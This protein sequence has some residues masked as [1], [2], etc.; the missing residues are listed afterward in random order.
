VLRSNSQMS[1][2]TKAITSNQRLA[3]VGAQVTTRPHRR[4]KGQG[5]LTRSEILAAARELLEAE[6]RKGTTIR[7]IA[8]KA[9]ISSTALYFY[10]ADLDAIL[11]EISDS[12]ST[13]LADSLTGDAKRH[14]DPLTAVESMLRSYVAFGLANPQAYALTFVDPKK[15]GQTV[16]IERSPSQAE[17]AVAQFV[18]SV[19]IALTSVGRNR[20]EGEKLAHLLWFSVHGLVCMAISRP[21]LLPG[22]PELLAKDMAKLLLKGGFT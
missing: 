18:E 8:E 14:K 3:K 16:S 21:E 19:G 20:R 10:F 12:I 1:T 17:R 11:I 5:G 22:K 15:F 6:G 7:A 13:W 4:A 9:G 2:K